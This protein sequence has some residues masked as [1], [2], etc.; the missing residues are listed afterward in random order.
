M[1]A[2]RDPDLLL[3]AFLDEGPEVL[4]DRALMA[5]AD[6][7]HRLRQRTVLRSVEALNHAYSSGVGRGP[8]DRRRRRGH[9]HGESAR[10]RTGQRADAIAVHHGSPSITALPEREGALDPGA[11]YDSGSFTHAFAFTVA[12]RDG[13]TIPRG[14][15]GWL[16]HVPLA[17]GKLAAPS[18]SMT[19]SICQT[20]C[21]SQPASCL[22]CQMSRSGSLA[23]KASSSR[24]WSSSR[25]AILSAR[26]WDIELG[27]DCYAGD[28]PPATRQSPSRPASITACTR[29]RSGRMSTGRCRSTRCWSPRGELAMGARATRSSTSSTR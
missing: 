10:S 13:S 29:C 6:D 28:N 9:L 27:P 7:V 15:V 23:A 24:R 26:Y 22:T 3:Q 11:T 1:S 21:A 14:H 8:C 5:I 12:G 16:P 20:I 4:P 17:T 25:A 2:T 18:P 19:G